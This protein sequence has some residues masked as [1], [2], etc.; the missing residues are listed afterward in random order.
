MDS[1]KF[2]RINSDFNVWYQ[3]LDEDDMSCPL[4]SIDY[5]WLIP[6]SEDT[7]LAESDCAY[8]RIIV[9][10]GTQE[11][12]TGDAGVFCFDSLYSLTADFAKTIS[13]HYPVYATFHVDRDSGVLG[14]AIDGTTW[15]A[16]K[17][18]LR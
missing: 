10:K 6:N 2:V 1:R 13:D 18:R 11:D 7:N 12:H 15:G 14:T 16:L 17:A 4:R 5:T 8:D 9:T 3:T